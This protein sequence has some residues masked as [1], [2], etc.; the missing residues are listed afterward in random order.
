VRHL[1]DIEHTK[2]RP[3]CNTAASLMNKADS[4]RIHELC[5]LIAVEQDRNKFLELVK[6]LNHILGKK[7]A[8]LH[9][10]EEDDNKSTP[11]S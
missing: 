5:S 4:D 9:N 10:E 7:E 11:L 6:E 1:F 8:R 2:P 3:A